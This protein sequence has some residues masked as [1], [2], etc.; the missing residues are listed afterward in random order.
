VFIDI[1][2]AVPGRDTTKHLAVIGRFRTLQ[3]PVF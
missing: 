3:K 1:G 2:D